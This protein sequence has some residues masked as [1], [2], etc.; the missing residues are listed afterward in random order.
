MGFRIRG[1]LKR[2][3]TTKAA[4]DCNNT[5]IVDEDNDKGCRELL[6]VRVRLHW[7]QSIQ[8]DS[9]GSIRVGMVEALKE[10]IIVGFGKGAA[11]QDTKNGNASFRKI[12]KIER[13]E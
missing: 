7:L 10:D 5:M 2:A 6:P 9:K 12:Y 4:L 11:L 3:K 8:A 1:M 13:P